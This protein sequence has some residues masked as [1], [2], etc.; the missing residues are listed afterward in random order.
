MDWIVYIIQAKNGKLYT[1]VTVDVKRRMRQHLGEIK[2]GAKFFRSNPPRYFW[3][4][5]I[6]GS[7]SEA[8]QEESRI[9]KLSKREKKQL[10]SL[11]TRSPC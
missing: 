8:Q 1:G 4:V 9:K 2:G 5:A 7:R 10:I 3:Q 11:E 6:F